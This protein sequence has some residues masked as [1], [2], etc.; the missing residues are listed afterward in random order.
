MIQTSKDILF[1]I[2]GLSILTISFFTCF[3]LYYLIRLIKKLYN[4][5]R[6]IEEVSGRLNEIVKTTER[7]IKEI[8]LLPLIAE[9]I[10][11]VIDFLKERKKNKEKEE[12]K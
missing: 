11:T 8:T 4:A 6:F 1:L 3:F 9:G 12:K 5:G 10:R 7:K 2:L